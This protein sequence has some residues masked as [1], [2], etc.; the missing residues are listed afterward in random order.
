MQK[1]DDLNN[2]INVWNQAMLNLI[3]NPTSYENLSE[4]LKVEMH[5]A[6]LAIDLFPLNYKF[7]PDKLKKSLSFAKKAVVL[8]PNN[9]KLVPIELKNNKFFIEVVKEN[10]YV[11]LYIEDAFLNKDLIRELKRLDSNIISLL[12]KRLADKKV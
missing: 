11:L 7:V 10:I 4:D 8:E 2:F 5:I 9:L 3:D 1:N 6:S 12:N